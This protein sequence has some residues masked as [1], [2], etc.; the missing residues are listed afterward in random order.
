MKDE[1]KKKIEEVKHA[2]EN[3]LEGMKNRVSMDIRS[4]QYVDLTE[5]LI[6]LNDSFEFMVKNREPVSEDILD[7]F[8]ISQKEISESSNLLTQPS[9]IAYLKGDQVRMDKK[10]K[11]VKTALSTMYEMTPLLLLLL[12]Y[13]LL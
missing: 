5:K 2:R 8:Y 4:R 12:I 9:T 13:L 11:L 7:Q 3:F 10:R 6:S 1:M